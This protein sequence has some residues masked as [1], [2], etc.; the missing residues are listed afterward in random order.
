MMHNESTTSNP[1]SRNSYLTLYDLVISDHWKRILSTHN[2]SIRKLDFTKA[3][4]PLHFTKSWTIFSLHFTKS[5][6]ILD[7]RPWLTQSPSTPSWIWLL[8]LPR[9]ASSTITF[10]KNF[11]NYHGWRLSLTIQKSTSHP[12]LMEP[13][14]YCRMFSQA[15]H[16]HQGGEALMKVS[17]CTWTNGPCM[18]FIVSTQVWFFHGASL[19][20]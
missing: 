7:L 13:I 10:W 16:Q 9:L 18:L 1:N 6:T 5:W 19:V 14:T 15:V 17:T 2:Q 20:C 12:S 11:A 4:S 8:L 3:F